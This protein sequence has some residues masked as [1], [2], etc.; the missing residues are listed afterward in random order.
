MR[1]LLKCKKSRK[2]FFQ[3]FCRDKRDHCVSVTS[4]SLYVL[5]ATSIIQHS[6]YVENLSPLFWLQQ[7]QSDTIHTQTHARKHFQSKPQAATASAYL[8]Q[9]L[10]PFPPPPLQLFL[11]PL[12]PL[13]LWRGRCKV[14]VEA[15]LSAV[16]D[17]LYGHHVDVRWLL[18]RKIAVI[19][20]AEV[21]P[22][23]LETKTS[24]LWDRI[25]CGHTPLQYNRK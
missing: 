5:A 6:I 10:L 23:E 18:R 3:S 14:G 12:L 7:L 4:S 25:D 16:H 9:P 13:S 11:F 8:S 24:E 20:W 2:P 21:L 19:R 22:T 15:G 1:Y 17:R